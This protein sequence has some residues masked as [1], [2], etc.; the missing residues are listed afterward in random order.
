MCACISVCWNDKTKM[1]L[2]KC[3]SNIYGDC[4]YGIYIGVFRRVFDETHGS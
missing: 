2:E 3:T 4:L 1:S